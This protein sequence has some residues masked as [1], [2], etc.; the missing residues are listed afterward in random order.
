MS[1]TL[2][3]YDSSRFVAHDISFTLN[4]SQQPQAYVNS[5]SVV[6]TA[7]STNWATPVS[8]LNAGD[9]VSAI[10]DSSTPFLWLPQSVCDSFAENLGLS[11]NESLQLYTFDENPSQRDTLQKASLNFT[12]GLS[13]LASSTDIVNI[14]LPYEAFDLEATF[15]FLNYTTYG[16]SNSTKYYFPLKVATNEAQ[17]TIGR[18]FL[19]EAYIITDYERNNFSVHQAIHTGDA[20]GDTSLVSITRYDKSTLSGN[21]SSPSQRLSSGAVAGIAIGIVAIC[22][23]GSFLIFWFWRRRHRATDNAS[24]KS[25]RRSFLGRLRNRDRRSERSD[26]ECHEFSGN[27][28]FPTEVG[29]DASH[30]RFE[31]PAPLGPAELESD[32]NTLSGTTE[33]GS[34]LDSPNMSAYERHRRKIDRQQAMAVHQAVY[35]SDEKAEQDVS[36]VVHYR[37]RI[38]SESGDTPLVSP[39][40]PPSGSGGSLRSRSGQPSPVTPHASNWPIPPPPPIYKHGNTAE[41]VY[42]GPLPDN[43]QLPSNLPSV[44][45][46]NNSN[47]N[48]TDHNVSTLGSHFTENENRSIPYDDLYSVS[49]PSESPSRSVFPP[50]SRRQTP[51][52]S[53]PDNSNSNRAQQR[54]ADEMKFLQEDMVKMKKEL[55]NNQGGERLLGEDLVHVPQPNE[56]RFSWQVEE[57]GGRKKE[58][59]GSK[60]DGD[61]IPE[62]REE[63]EGDEEAER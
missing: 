14:T 3:G 11:Y 60:G 48:T 38:A 61:G 6:S 16:A 47:S 22:A 36:T 41:G 57:G 1:L 30:E 15:P 4:P 17:Y 56:K 27:S 42:A 50:Q 24:E 43:V 54:E 40:G 49:S 39:L 18:A 29:A 28:S 55:K 20:L 46:E 52:G 19:Q 33:N 59:E 23:L 13:N 10:I 2:G 9:S 35:S 37:P 53:E 26:S 5:I 31:L 25:M 7:A 63:R 51:P 8:L 44:N 45:G 62:E 34:T 58:G 12:F 32:S 21:P